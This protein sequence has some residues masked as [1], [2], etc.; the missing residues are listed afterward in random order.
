MLDKH[1]VRE[2]SGFIQWCVSQN[3]RMTALLVTPFSELYPH[4][5][6]SNI[7]TLQNLWNPSFVELIFL[8]HSFEHI[9]IRHFALN[10]QISCR[11]SVSPCQLKFTID[12]SDVALISD[13]NVSGRVHYMQHISVFGWM[14]THYSHL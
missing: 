6:I 13:W 12:M 11:C 4:D 3:S 2:V 1:E 9:Y 10:H 14:S 8:P 5:R 7:P